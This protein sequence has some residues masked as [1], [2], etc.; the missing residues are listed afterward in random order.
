MCCMGHLC[1]YVSGA[2]VA[3]VCPS[4]DM[5]RER[6]NITVVANVKPHLLSRLARL[7]GATILQSVNH[8]DKVCSPVCAC[9][10]LIA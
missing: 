9:G 4:Q 2:A 6:A 7:T 8:L 3:C 5:L 10:S 1:L